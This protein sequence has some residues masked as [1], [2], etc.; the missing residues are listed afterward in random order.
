MN[1][2]TKQEIR[3]TVILPIELNEKVELEATSEKRSKAQQINWI[4]E[5]FFQGKQQTENAQIELNK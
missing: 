1:T 3:Y 5:K 4:L 2:E